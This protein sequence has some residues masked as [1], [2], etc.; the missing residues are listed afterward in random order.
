MSGI[1]PVKIDGVGVGS[2]RVAEDGTIMLIMGSPCRLGH[3]ILKQIE[4][5]IVSGLEVRPIINPM[6]DGRLIT[7]MDNES[8]V[9]ND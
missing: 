7:R 5:G 6:V 3:E 4:I 9:H 1:V 2:A 8:I